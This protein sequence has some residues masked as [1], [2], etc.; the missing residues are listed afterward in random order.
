VLEGRI[1]Q[2]PADFRVTE[3]LGFRPSGEGDHDF[4]YVEKTGA[5]TNWVAKSLARHA[6]VPPRDVGFSGMKD[7]QAVTKQWFSVPRSPKQPT[8][9]D[10][11]DLPDVRI[12]ERERNLKKLKRGSHAANRFR[13]RIRCCDQ[14]KATTDA[15]L[16]LI[17]ERGVPNYFGAQR[18]GHNG[19]NLDLARAVLDGARV[20][21]DKRSIALSTARS[22]LFNEVLSER[23][24]N[25]TWNT[26]QPGDVMN[27][28]GS[29]SFFALETIDEE[30]SVRCEEQD[31]HP[32][33]PLWGRGVLASGRDVAALEKQIAA[34]HADLSGG[35]ERFGVDMQRRA[36]RL[37]VVELEWEWIEGSVELRFELSRGGYATSVIRELADVES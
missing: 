12:C 7:R 15:R 37:R 20:K 33:G 1:K 21:R 13:I 22:F 35:L 14:D 24:K 6:G 23:V 9:W 32:T 10:A 29:G 31:I 17:A 34:R 4:L 5:N 11:L 28:D 18:F 27:L 30:I 26:P 3:D 8:D 16:H 36:L 2:E 19:R 25:G